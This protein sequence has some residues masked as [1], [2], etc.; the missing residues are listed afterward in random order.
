MGA[1]EPAEPLNKDAELIQRGHSWQVIFLTQLEVLFSTAR[2]YVNY[3]CALNLA[4]FLPRDN[5]VSVNGAQ[6]LLGRKL[7]EWTI[8]GP[9]DHIRPRKLSD[10]LVA[11][12]GKSSI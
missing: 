2:C 8:I 4:Y 6:L 11:S 9:A 7:I 12:F 3:A 10:C 1:R 5:S